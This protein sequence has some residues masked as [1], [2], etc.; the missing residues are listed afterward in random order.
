[1]VIIAAA[2]GNLIIRMKLMLQ[3]NYL[4]ELSSDNLLNKAYLSTVSD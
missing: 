2:L 3:Q 4:R 1:M